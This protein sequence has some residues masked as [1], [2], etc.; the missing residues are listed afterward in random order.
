VVKVEQN[1]NVAPINM[2][3]YHTV[4]IEPKAKPSSQIDP[5]IQAFAQKIE[6][7]TTEITQ[8]QKTLMNRMTTLE[9]K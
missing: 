8:G 7:F 3:N 5:I 6:N 1:V 4:R 2:F 9:R